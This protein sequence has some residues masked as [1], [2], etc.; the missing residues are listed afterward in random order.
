MNH[1]MNYSL[2]LKNK[3]NNKLEE[4]LLLI[5]VLFFLILS[6]ACSPVFSQELNKQIGVNLATQFKQYE[7]SSLISVCYTNQRHY[8]SLGT[9]FFNLNDIA[10]VAKGINGQ[11]RIYPNLPFDNCE[12]FFSTGFNFHRKTDRT[13]VKDFKY[14]SNDTISFNAD[15]ENKVLQTGF[16]IGFGFQLNLLENFY[17]SGSFSN[18]LYYNLT[19]EKIAVQTNPSDL[20]LTSDGTL[21][22]FSQ[23]YLFSLGYNFD[24]DRIPVLRDVNDQY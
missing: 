16:N 10:L 14:F 19:T 24:I 20:L 15:Y 11:Y 17:F 18:N 3:I 9:S 5:K 13:T 23:M 2:N 6:L 22:I 1:Q 7:V 4:F 8:V 21:K 12:L